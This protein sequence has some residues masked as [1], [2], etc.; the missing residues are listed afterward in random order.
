LG[1]ALHSNIKQLYEHRYA[2]LRAEAALLGSDKALEFQDNWTALATSARSMLEKHSPVWYEELRGM[3]SAGVPWEMLLHMSTEYEAEMM[4]LELEYGNTTALSKIKRGGHCSGVALLGPAQP[5][6]DLLTGQT[7][8]E[9]VP[10][11]LNGTVD[12]VIH[13]VDRRKSS[14]AGPGLVFESLYYTHPGIGAY[15]GLNSAGLTV[16]WQTLDDGSRSSSYTGLPT[17]A[18]LRELLT[19]ENAEQAAK[20]LCD[21]PM[22]IP[23]NF[24]ISSFGKAGKVMVNV[25]RSAESGSCSIVSQG[26]GYMAHTNH[27]I[28]ERIMMDHDLYLQHSKKVTPTH[29]TEDRLRTVLAHAR[30]QWDTG[31]L[32]LPALK[33]LFSSGL[34]VQNPATLAT[35]LLAPRNG[36]LQV[37]FFEDGTSQDSFRTYCLGT[38]SSSS[39]G[40]CHNRQPE[41]IFT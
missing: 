3:A 2:S 22:A 29:E 19:F 9:D 4:L 20:W 10:G 32:S 40:L 8:D 1:Q 5:V 18:A 7:N 38:G 14:E 37:R 11:W 30:K 33:N 24:M 16:L 26:L 28:Y 35:I 23:N 15:M 13:N 25:E 27:A 12:V 36:E 41:V 21:V 34:P 39:T 17:T 31:D 6:Q